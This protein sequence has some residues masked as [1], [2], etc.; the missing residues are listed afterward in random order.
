MGFTTSLETT[1]R[2]IISKMGGN[3]LS[4]VKRATEGV[5]MEFYKTEIKNQTLKKIKFTKKTMPPAFSPNQPRKEL[6]LLRRPTFLIPLVH[7]YG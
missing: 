6:L 7:P 4:V 1:F 2:F 5:I 3:L